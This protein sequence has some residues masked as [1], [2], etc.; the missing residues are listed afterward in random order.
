MCPIG[1]PYQDQLDQVATE[2][3]ADMEEQPS[4]DGS[5]LEPEKGLKRLVVKPQPSRKTMV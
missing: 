2:P 4:V 5:E 3:V 1:A